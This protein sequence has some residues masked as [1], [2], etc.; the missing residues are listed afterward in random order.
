MLTDQRSLRKMM[1]GN[2]DVAKTKT[3]FRQNLKLFYF[4]CHNAT[5]SLCI[6]KIICYERRQTLKNIQEIILL[7][8]AFRIRRR[9]NAQILKA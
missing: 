5:A 3:I 6:L 9:T 4:L 1:I 7:C 2:T 8:H